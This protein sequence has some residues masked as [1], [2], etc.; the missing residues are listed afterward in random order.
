MSELTELY[1]IL[2][3]RFSDIGASLVT[4]AK[5]NVMLELSPDQENAYE[6][7]QERL[8][9]LEECERVILWCKGIAEKHICSTNTL[10]IMPREIDMS[11]SRG[12]TRLIN[13]ES[14]DDP[15]ARR[16]YVL[17]KSNELYIE[18]K[19]SQLQEILNV[20][21]VNDEDE[22]EAAIMSD[23]EEQIANELRELMDSDDWKKFEE[24]LRGGTAEEAVLPA[25][26]QPPVPQ[27]GTTAETE[28]IEIVNPAEDSPNN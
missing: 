26:E 15:Y 8:K 5:A 20:I 23:H 27:E 25:D 6:T 13:L 11:K 21:G 4:E 24:L 3:K 22:V 2:Q 14:H 10:P 9:T 7:V 16:V 18:K 28:E 12:W 17:A 19:R 1:R